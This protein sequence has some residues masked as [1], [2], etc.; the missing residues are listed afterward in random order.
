ML[1][2]KAS[3][4]TKVL[5]STL[6]SVKRALTALSNCPTDVSSTGEQRLEV[7]ALD[8]RQAHRGELLLYDAP[9]VLYT[10]SSLGSASQGHFDA[11]T[12]LED[13]QEFYTWRQPLFF[14]PA[15]LEQI[16]NLGRSGDNDTHRVRSAAND[17]MASD[18]SRWFRLIAVV[19][20]FNLALALHLREEQPTL[21]AQNLYYSA[22]EMALESQE[23]DEEEIHPM[24]VDLSVLAGNNL[25]EISMELGDFSGAVN[26]MN[27]QG[28]LIHRCLSSLLAGQVNQNRLLNMPV[29]ANLMT[30]C[31]VIRELLT[32]RGNNKNTKGEEGQGM[33]L[34]SCAPAA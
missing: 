6:G 32:A 4:S 16:G 3:A 17:M 34:R 24:F 2:G 30:G 12:C 23:D 10:A 31:I 26:A 33:P 25:L 15:S 20:T 9:S 11:G 8:V 19:T 28:T 5:R 21:C 22:I 27:I 29:Y 13:S 7:E 14:S 18:V 1:R